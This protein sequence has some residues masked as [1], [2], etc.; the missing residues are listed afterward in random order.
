MSR[1]SRRRGSAENVA[2]SAR[3]DLLRIM[4]D[5]LM[6]DR[7]AGESQKPILSMIIEIVDRPISP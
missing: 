4:S 2:A 1:I 6:K 7:R 3:I 5:V